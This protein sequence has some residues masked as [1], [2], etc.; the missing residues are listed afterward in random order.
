MRTITRCLFLLLIIGGDGSAL[1]SQTA[2][3]RWRLLPD[4]RVGSIDVPNYALTDVSDLTVGTDGTFYILQPLEQRLR[5]YDQNGQFLR[6]VGRPGDGPGEFRFPTNIGWVGDTLWISDG[7]QLRVTFLDAKGEVLGTSP[8]AVSSLGP[9][10]LPTTAQ[11]L[12]ADGT[13]IVQPLV[14]SRSLAANDISRAPLLR[15]DR[16]GSVLDTVAWLPLRNQY[17]SVSNPD[18]SPPWTSYSPQPFA[19]PPLWSVTPDRASVIL[20][21]VGERSRAELGKIKVFELTLAGD[22]IRSA[23]VQYTPVPL[24]SKMVEEV[25]SMRAEH[26]FNVGDGRIASRAAAERM[27][28]DELYVPATLP[29]VSEVIAASNGSI[30]LQRESMASDA[31]LWQIL[32]TDGQVEAILSTPPELKILLVTD[33]HVWGVEYDELQIPYVVRLRIDKPT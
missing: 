2:T 26:F 10:F 13:A 22:T 12:M 33:E 16:I 5:I 25:I 17:F 1:D 3:E 23:D 7:V 11:T 19:D 6:T 4:L 14:S 30:W 8:L 9:G 28:Q 27:I 32:G 31:N 24:T 29:P 15:T 20:V 21:D 18:A